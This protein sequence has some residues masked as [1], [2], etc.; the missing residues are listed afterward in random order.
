MPRVRA[1]PCNLGGLAREATPL[2][3][4]RRMISDCKLQR[5]P[6]HPVK[7]SRRSPSVVP[8]P[9]VSAR[10]IKLAE[11]Q[12]LKPLSDPLNQKCQG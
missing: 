9:A 1:A 8:R 6:D 2:K 7:K 3:G 5:T 4:F 12:V 11:V 10:T